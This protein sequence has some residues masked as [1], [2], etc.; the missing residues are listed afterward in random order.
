[1]YICGF[2]STFQR[3]RSDSLYDLF[4]SHTMKFDEKE[5]SG[6]IIFM[7]LFNIKSVN[8]ESEVYVKVFATNATI[9]KCSYGQHVLWWRYFNIADISVRWYFQLSSEVTES[10]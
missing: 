3:K 6:N 1:M 10:F 4:A 2:F 5:K 9:P 7:L 8:R